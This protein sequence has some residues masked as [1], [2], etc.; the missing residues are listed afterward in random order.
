ML[1][2]C[3]Q[4]VCGFSTAGEAKAQSRDGL[5]SVSALKS[6]SKMAEALA[7][8]QQS[9]MASSKGVEKQGEVCFV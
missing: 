2:I 8:Q 7:E 6:D 5:M 1:R 3:Q 4:G 9:A